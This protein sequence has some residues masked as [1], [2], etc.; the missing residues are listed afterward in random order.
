VGIVAI[1]GPGILPILTIILGDFEGPRPCFA[2]AL[3][4]MMTDCQQPSP[5]LRYWGIFPL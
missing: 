1:V 5:G 3:L 2:A 4:R